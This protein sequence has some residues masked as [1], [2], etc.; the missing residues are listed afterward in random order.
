MNHVQGEALPRGVCD[1]GSRLAMWNMH[2][3]CKDCKDCR[4]LCLKKLYRNH[5]KRKREGSGCSRA[6]SQ[7]GWEGTPRVLAPLPQ[8]P[9]VTRRA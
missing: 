2:N 1:M 5:Q 7:V 4:S 6:C 9:L 3:P 8:T